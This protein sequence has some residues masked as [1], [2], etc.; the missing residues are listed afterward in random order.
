MTEWSKKKGKEKSTT[1]VR[2]VNKE[3]SPRRS[4]S[5]SIR[6]EPIPE[7]IEEATIARIS[8]SDIS[9]P[10]TAN[11]TTAATTISPPR[12]AKSTIK[13]GKKRAIAEVEQPIHLPPPAKSAP[14]KR[15][16]KSASVVPDVISV[17]EKEKG[18][19]GKRAISQVDA[20]TEI[21]AP[22]VAKKPRATKAKKLLAVST[23]EEEWAR[24]SGLKEMSSKQGKEKAVEMEVEPGAPPKKKVATKKNT[25]KQVEPVVE[26]QEDSIIVVEQPIVKQKARKKTKPAVVLATT[27]PA[28]S[29][30]RK[31]DLAESE[32]HSPIARKQKSKSTNA[33]AS[34]S[35]VTL[36]VQASPKKVSKVAKVVGKKVARVESSVNYFSALSTRS[37]LHRL[38]LSS[39]ISYE[40]SLAQSETEC[41]SKIELEVEVSR[42]YP[43]NRRRS[44]RTSCGRRIRFRGGTISI[45][46]GKTQLDGFIGSWDCGDASPRVVRLQLAPPRSLPIHAFAGAGKWLH[47]AQ[48]RHPSNCIEIAFA[49]SSSL[50]YEPDTSQL[51][52]NDTEIVITVR[53]IVRSDGRSGES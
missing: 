4:R 51:P 31:V 49:C 8:P 12:H 28:K 36:G 7:A 33:A 53:S 50:K 22:A 37:S 48:R 30:K 47:R 46:S 11:A 38:Q 42:D 10:A 44:S 39:P 35:K 40:T 17:V 34:S 9:T 27:P 52:S 18:T 24:V 3:Y 45:K 25:T 26:A 43:I 5:R 1:G 16:S 14:T 19:K 29:G 32:D 41:E 6:P 13:A 21:V 20:E 23:E 15:K 2:S